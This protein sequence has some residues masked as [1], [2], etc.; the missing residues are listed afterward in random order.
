[1]RSMPEPAPNR[2]R[3]AADWPIA[4]AVGL[5]ALA[6]LLGTSRDIALSFD[7]A[8][9]IRRETVLADWFARLADPPPGTSRS[10]LFRRPVLEESWRFSRRE[11]DGHPPFYALLGL[12]GWRATR[13][14]LDPPASYRFGPMA[15]TAA[16]CAALYLHLARRRGRLAGLAAPL[17]MLLMPR[18]FTHAHYAHYDM[19]VSCLW[20]LAQLAFVNAQGAAWWSVPFGLVLGLAWATKLT[21]WFALAPP[22]AWALLFEIGPG[23]AAWLRSSL[24]E[25]PRAGRPR[26]PWPAT[27]AVV[28]GAAVA[29][30]VVYA[31]QPAWWA[32]PIAGLRRFFASNLSREQ[33]VP[34]PALYF[35][36]VYPFA[37]PWHNAIVLTAITTPALTVVLG[38][39]GLV[40]TVA[41]ARS[42]PTALIWPLSFAAVLVVRALP[43]SPGHDVERLL[44]PGLTSLAVLAGLGVQGL[45]DR[46]RPTRWK[47]LPYALLGGAV[48]ESAM[49]FAQYYPYHLSYY[50]AAIGGLPGAVRA[51]FDPTYY[52]DTLGPEFARWARAQPHP[53]E[54][55]FPFN[56][57]SAHY[58]RTWGELPADLRIAGLDPTDRP[59]YVLQRDLP[60]YAPWDHALEREARPVFTIRRRGVPLLHVYAPEDAE[61]A[62][63]N[64]SER[65]RRP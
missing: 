12:A 57:L 31:I 54:L 55:R 38:L 5:A 59:Y 65:R 62:H 1:M 26:R 42:E 34:V 28:V 21:G 22:L 64:A 30:M 25:G 9:T 48:V 44:L 36:A 6:A 23:A 47:A 14:W 3:A 4:A 50:N 61:R 27:R 35:G 49:G 15:L 16:T 56:E 29:M 17:L 7:E 13:G 8:F 58:L 46:L 20:L 33:V 18:V 11:P 32:D 10:D 40:L 60:V 45:A 2:P 39:I 37:L 52:W 51:G 19:P 24:V 63:R 41:R 53:L 43:N